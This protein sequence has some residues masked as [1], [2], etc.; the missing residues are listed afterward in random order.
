MRAGREM[1]HRYGSSD[2]I[3]VESGRGVDGVSVLGVD[4]PAGVEFPVGV[5][6]MGV[7]GAEFVGVRAAARCMN[8]RFNVDDESPPAILPYLS[9]RMLIGDEDRDD[10]INLGVPSRSSRARLIDF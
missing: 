3:R 6:A 7:D 2:A 9:V 8:L 10:K 4:D 1:V 5:W